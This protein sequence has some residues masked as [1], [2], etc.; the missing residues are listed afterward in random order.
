MTES[1]ADLDERLARLA[2]RRAKSPDAPPATG[3]RRRHP[4][5][6]TRILVAGLSAAGF[7]SIVASIGTAA[8]TTTAAATTSAAAT[9]TGT[10]ARSPSGPGVTAAGPK[11]KT[12]RGHKPPVPP[13]P[14][15]PTATVAPAPGTQ[16]ATHLVFSAPAGAPPPTSTASPAAPTSAVPT[17]APPVGASPSPAPHTPPSTAPHV[18]PTPT[19]APAP[20][21]TTVFTP[22]PPPP[23][24]PCFGTRCP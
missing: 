9:T 21:P 22:P 13:V 11:P 14:A 18:S 23:P 24:P 20:T 5:G 17:P 1:T 6:A 12:R 3:P 2:A 8:T 10:V 7:L 16:A 19:S 15:R 4:A